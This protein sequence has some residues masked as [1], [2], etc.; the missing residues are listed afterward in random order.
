MDKV[1]KTS[2]SQCYIPSSEPFRSHRHSCLTQN[3]YRLAPVMKGSVH[4]SL[5]SEPNN[6]FK[7]FCTVL[8]TQFT[9]CS[10]INTR[11]LGCTASLHYTLLFLH[12]CH[13]I[14]LFTYLFT[15][16]LN[17]SSNNFSF[18]TSNYLLCAHRTAWNMAT[19][20]KST[21]RKHRHTILSII[22][23][24]VT[25]KVRLKLFPPKRNAYSL[26]Q[27]Y[28]K[29]KLRIEGRIEMTGRRGR[30]RK[31][32]LNDLK[33]KRRY[34]K[35]KETHKIAPCGELALEDATGLS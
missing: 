20:R 19:Q 29:A 22:L 5:K 25:H 34:W 12:F 1:Q 27:N 31:Q 17:G 21:T 13:F 18:K 8:N 35:L 10:R 9:N 24:G 2:G 3:R 23:N 14:L 15:W 28:K 26:S 6:I 7:G 16:K 30:R 11:Q 33:K 4:R 32:L